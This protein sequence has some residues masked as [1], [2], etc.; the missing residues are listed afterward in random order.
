MWHQTDKNWARYAQFLNRLSGHGIF[1]LLFWPNCHPT[2]TIHATLFTTV[3]WLFPYPSRS[4]V[5]VPNVSRSLAIFLLLSP[6]AS[7]FF[8]YLSYADYDYLISPFHFCC[9]LSLATYVFLS[10]SSLCSSLRSHQRSKHKTN[11]ISTILM[12]QRRSTMST[13]YKGLSRPGPMARDRSSSPSPG[14]KR[15]DDVVLNH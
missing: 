1:K 15:I 7:L 5:I 14:A 8:C 4:L 6:Y 10:F 9:Y 11:M 3:S 2:F 13:P 12:A